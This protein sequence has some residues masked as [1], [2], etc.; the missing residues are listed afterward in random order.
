M[1]SYVRPLS[2]IVLEFLAEFY[3]SSQSHRLPD[4]QVVLLVQW[5]VASFKIVVFKIGDLILYWENSSWNSIFLVAWSDWLF[6]SSKIQCFRG[7]FLKQG[8]FRHRLLIVSQQ[9]GKFFV[10]VW[11]FPYLLLKETGVVLLTRIIIQH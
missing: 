10:C 7:L 8:F 11:I 3:I 2:P 4:W 5:N 6:I 1:Q 9:C